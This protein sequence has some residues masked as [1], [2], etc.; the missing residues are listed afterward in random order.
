MAPAEAASSGKL[1]ARAPFAHGNALTQKATATVDRT[2]LVRAG[3]SSYP[4][5]RGSTSC[6]E[7]LPGPMSWTGAEAICATS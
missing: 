1:N 5:P 7:T 4:N 3:W 2:G 6:G